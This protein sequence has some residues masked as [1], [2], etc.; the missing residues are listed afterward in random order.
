M[1]VLQPS[2]QHIE[3]KV[4]VFAKF[5]RFNS[6]EVELLDKWCYLRSQASSR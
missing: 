2:C 1:T 5:E 3:F 4:G 6:P